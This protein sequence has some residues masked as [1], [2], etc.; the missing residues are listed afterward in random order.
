MRFLAISSAS[1]SETE[2]GSASLPQRHLLLRSTSWYRP[3]DDITGSYCGPEVRFADVTT[4]LL[5][6]RLWPTN[7]SR[8]FGGHKRVYR[9]QSGTGRLLEWRRTTSAA[10]RLHNLLNRNYCGCLSS[11]LS[12]VKVRVAPLVRISRAIVEKIVASTQNTGP[13]MLGQTGV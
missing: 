12:P 13:R 11:V 3:S 5:E 2:E 10:S 1:R 7:R 8:Q 4:D 9:Y 6:P